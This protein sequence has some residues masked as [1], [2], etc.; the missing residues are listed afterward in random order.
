[1]SLGINAAMRLQLASLVTD[2]N[3]HIIGLCNKSIM[4]S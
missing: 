3:L 2:L 4:D 1:M